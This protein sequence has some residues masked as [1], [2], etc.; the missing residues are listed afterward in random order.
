MVHHQAYF[1]NGLTAHPNLR[2]LDPFS[3]NR[4]FVNGVAGAGRSRVEAQKRS[5]ASR[6]S[7]GSSRAPSGRDEVLLEQADA[8]PG[9]WLH[10]HDVVAYSNSPRVRH[11][12]EEFRSD[13][14]EW[15]VRGRRGDDPVFVPAALVFAPLPR[16]QT[17]YCHRLSHRMVLPPILKSA[18]HISE[19]GSKASS[20]TRFSD[21]DWPTAQTRL[22]RSWL[23]RFRRMLSRTENASARGPVFRYLCSTRR[24]VFR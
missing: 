16:S 5:A 20:T 7:S 10:P 22:V 13:Q 14:P 23:L 1:A 8:L 18:R 17:G 24:Q 3:T 2:A 15:W 4:Q 21:R 19:P 11:S 12:L 9:D 6:E